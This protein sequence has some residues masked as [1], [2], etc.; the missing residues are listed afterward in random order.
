MRCLLGFALIHMSV[1]LNT[2]LRVSQ[3]PRFYGVTTRGSV[4]FYCLSSKQH[5]EARARWYKVGEYHE[6]PDK[7]EEVK[8]GGRIDIRAKA[9]TEGGCLCIQDVHVEDRGVFFCRVNNTWGPGSEL[10]V[11]R[12]LSR[13]HALHKTEMKDGLIVLHAL[14]LAVCIAAMLLRQRKLKLEKQDSEYE[15]PETHHVY[16]GLAVE[17]C[18]GGLYEELSVYYAQPEGAEAPWE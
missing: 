8:A 3:K 7:G 17:T 12:P 6:E 18:G 1:A 10:Q 11:A 15:E 16:E 2:A 13:I 14:L 5:L 4:C 9:L